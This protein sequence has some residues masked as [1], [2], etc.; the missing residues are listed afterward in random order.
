MIGK[1]SDIAKTI[2][3]R[4]YL[5]VG[6]ISES[7]LISLRI[8]NIQRVTFTFVVK[9]ALGTV[10]ISNGYNNVV[11]G[12]KGKTEGGIIIVGISLGIDG[13][14]TFWVYDPGLIN[15]RVP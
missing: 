1:H 15:V 9:N 13:F 10:R 5:I 8:S 3:Y 2:G 4:N 6:V 7:E 14:T 12:I 11:I